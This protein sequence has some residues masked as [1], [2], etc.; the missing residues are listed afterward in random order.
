MNERGWRVFSIVF[1]VVIMT[2][3]LG[4]FILQPLDL[5]TCEARG[6]IV[7]TSPNCDSI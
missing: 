3:I 6:G 4:G 1:G 7:L 5:A 2:L